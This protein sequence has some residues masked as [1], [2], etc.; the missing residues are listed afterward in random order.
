MKGST[1][2][3]GA[4]REVAQLDRDG[5]RFFHQANLVAADPRVKYIFG[6]AAEEYER[7][8]KVLTSVAGKT[9]RRPEVPKVFPFEDYQ[10][11][12]CYVCGYEAEAEELPEMC[13]SCGAARYAFEREMTQSAAWDLVARTTRKVST[14]ARKAVPRVPKEGMKA[15]L[16]EAMA[17]RKGLLAEAKEGK[18]RGDSS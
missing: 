18:A 7:A 2:R 1:R 12:E 5:A 16:A 13:P 8:A 6:R 4:I 3:V 15:A 14:F 11:L 9:K 10:R 17:I